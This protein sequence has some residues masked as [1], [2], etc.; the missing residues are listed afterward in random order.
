MALSF[1]VA[2]ALVAHNSTGA[3]RR[4]GSNDACGIFSMARCGAFSQR[5]G[6]AMTLWHCGAVA[7]W[8]CGAQWPLAA[9][10]L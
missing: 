1:A 8:R 9:V 4:S 5:C 6:N 10:A 7:L 3:Q 2:L